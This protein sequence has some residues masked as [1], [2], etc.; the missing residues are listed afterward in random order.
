MSVLDKILFGLEVTVIGLVV[1]FL[2]LIILIYIIKLLGVSAG[3]IE[4][5]SE[6][7]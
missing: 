6:A 2:V 4:M 7:R 1:V 3:K 5:A